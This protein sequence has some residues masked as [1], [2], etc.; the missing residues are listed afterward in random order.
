MT[1]SPAMEALPIEVIMRLAEEF[2]EA[3]S[4]HDDSHIHGQGDIPEP[5]V[6]REALRAYALQAI[7]AAKPQMPQDAKKNARLLVEMIEAGWHQESFKPL[8]DWLRAQGL[9]ADGG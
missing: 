1:P 2:A 3:M 7:A 6:E 9:T 8:A 4:S 5:I